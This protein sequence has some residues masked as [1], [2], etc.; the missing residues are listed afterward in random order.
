M[1]VPHCTMA[2]DKHKLYGAA[3]RYCAI[4]I[5]FYI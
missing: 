3:G 4:Y 2:A 1:W 5:K